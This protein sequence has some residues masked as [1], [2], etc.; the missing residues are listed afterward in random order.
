MSD[1]HLFTIREMARELALPESTVRYYRD[2]FARHLPILGAGARR[3]Y[4]DETLRRLRLVAEGYAAGR[5]RHEIEETLSEEGDVVVEWGARNT[6]L[7]RNDDLVAAIVEGEQERREAMWQ[8][9]SEIV[10][11]GEAIERQQVMLSTIADRLAGSA[12][13]TLPPS[14]AATAEQEEETIPVAEAEPIRSGVAAELETLREQLEQERDLVERLR[15]SKVEMER[16]AA[17][18]EARIGEGTPVDDAATRSIL[19]RLLF[20]GGRAR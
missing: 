6:S 2:V 13:R 11:L 20:G 12:D 4:T 17:E 19:A 18:A 14:E 7:A 9:A 3:L 16:R 15:R 1:A 8:M 10:R 5:R